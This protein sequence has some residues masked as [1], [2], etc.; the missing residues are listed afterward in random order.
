MSLARRHY[1]GGAGS[2]IFFSAG[3][4]EGSVAPAAAVDVTG[5][6]V[7]RWYI[8]TFNAGGRYTIIQTVRRP[9]D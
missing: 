1:T 3:G 5:R 4:T 8:S 2:R 7:R 9:V 6:P